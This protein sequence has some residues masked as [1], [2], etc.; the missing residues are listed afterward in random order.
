MRLNGLWLK[1]WLQYSAIALRP[2]SKAKTQVCRAVRMSP[3]EI[4]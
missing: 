1:R 3:R 2:V 4:L